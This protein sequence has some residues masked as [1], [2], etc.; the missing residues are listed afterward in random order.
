[1][2]IITQNEKWIKINDFCKQKEDNNEVVAT[3]RI[4]IDD[5][6]IQSLLFPD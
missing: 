3:N 2:I 5:M 1:M 4:F 6:S